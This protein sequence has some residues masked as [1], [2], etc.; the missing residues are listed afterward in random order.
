MMKQNQNKT[1][2]VPDN[3]FGNQNSARNVKD[4]LHGKK[5]PIS[6]TKPSSEVTGCWSVEE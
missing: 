2:V 6:H 4:Q 5:K 3:I 1:A